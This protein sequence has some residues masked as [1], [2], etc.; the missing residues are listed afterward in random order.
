M[1]VTIEGAVVPPNPSFTTVTAN[2]VTLATG[3]AGSAGTG[4]LASG[5]LTVN[6]TAVTANSII[7][8]TV[9]TPAGATQGVKLAIPTRT[10]GTSFVVN[11]VDATG[12]TVATDTSTFDW[13]L[14]N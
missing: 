11:A 12:A 8:A 6:T 1:A 13:V 7:Q 2:K 5:T 4:T 14:F 10:P 9:R 3:A